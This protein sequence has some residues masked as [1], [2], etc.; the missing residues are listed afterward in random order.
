M[1]VRKS[2]PGCRVAAAVGVLVVLADQLIEELYHQPLRRIRVH[3]RAADSRHHPHAQR[4][5]GLQLPRHGLGLAALAVHRAGGGGEHRESSYGCAACRAVAGLLACGLALVLGGAIG[6]VID[7]IRL[8]A[9]GR[10]HPLS[11]GSRVF[12]GVQRRRF[13]DHGRRGVSDRWMRCS[14]PNAAQA[15]A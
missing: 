3:H 4:R 7:R 15:K 6:N 14:N 1:S 5:R 12:S 13:R 8:G 10:F 11:L 2:R 9:C